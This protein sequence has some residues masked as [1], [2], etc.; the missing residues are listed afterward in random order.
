MFTRLAIDTSYKM[1]TVSILGCG[2][3]GLPLAEYLI[4]KGYTVKG[5]TRT[6]GK[7]KVLKNKGVKPFLIDLDPYLNGGD[8]DDFFKSDI[9]VINFPP[10][11]RD[12]VV[13]YHRAQINS[14]LSRI[15][16]SQVEK[17]LFISSTSVYPELNREVYEDEEALPSKLSGKALLEAEGI[18]KGSDDFQTT[19][20]RF[21]GLIGYDR[22]P[23]RFLAG[24]REIKNGDSPVN[25]IHRDDCIEIICRIIEENIWGETFN[26]CA[27]LHPKR[28]DYYVAQALKMG[29][30]PPVFSPGVKTGFKMVN[31][32]RLKR[33]L[34]YKFKYPDPSLID[35][36][37]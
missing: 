4:E 16:I 3:L 13:D 11:R 1:E 19:V 2:W 18:L 27:D 34:N 8:S 7:L 20:I 10:E 5:S 28:K 23:G 9:L 36:N 25:L 22:K 37:R 24:K 26:A 21:G 12:D 35:N 33:V 17:L 15:K 14:L 32:D 6:L 30:E 29:L 31:S